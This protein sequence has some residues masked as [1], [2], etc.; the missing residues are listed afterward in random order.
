MLS[1]VREISDRMQKSGKSLNL[2]DVIPGVEAPA[3]KS[4]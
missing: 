1:M 2:R 4:D 3:A